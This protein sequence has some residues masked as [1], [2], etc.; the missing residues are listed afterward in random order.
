MVRAFEQVS[1][2]K[3]VTLEECKREGER[4]E[5]GKNQL[6]RG[7]SEMNSC[8]RCMSAE[9][10]LVHDL[11]SEGELVGHVDWLRYLSTGMMCR[12]SDFSGARRD[13]LVENPAVGFH[14]VI[15]GCSLM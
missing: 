14:A 15:G 4:G 3:R 11:A 6:R 7:I 2:D 9:M 10:C 5:E 8:A 12:C 13:Y 1:R